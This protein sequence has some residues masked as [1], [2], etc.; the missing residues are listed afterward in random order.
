MTEFRDTT[1]SSPSLFSVLKNAL[2]MSMGRQKKPSGANHV[3]NQLE[4]PSRE[5][6]KINPV[7]MG[8]M[9]N[10]GE[11]KVKQIATPKLKIVVKHSTKKSPNPDSS[12]TDGARTKSI[13]AKVKF[14]PQLA[15]QDKETASRPAK[16][17][18]VARVKTKPSEAQKSRARTDLN[19][20]EP[21]AKRAKKQKSP[22]K[23]MKAK[24]T[25]SKTVSRT[26]GKSK[27]SPSKPK[28]LKKARRG[29]ADELTQI[30]GIG[31]R[32]E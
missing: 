28:L 25:K 10:T 3:M 16:G 23:S 5:I 9:S 1:P 32:I 29:K 12:K 13:R 4:K 27:K 17:I 18:P 26:T 19:G 30:C 2:G 21:P 22:A 7:Q 6:V 8:A 15:D 11:E 20:K 31:P 24:A 14:S